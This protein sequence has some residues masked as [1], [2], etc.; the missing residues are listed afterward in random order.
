MLDLLSWLIPNIGYDLI[1]Q[2]V[3]ALVLYTGVVALLG[4]ITKTI[5]GIWRAFWAFIIIFVCVFI[6]SA[7]IRMPNPSPNI[8]ASQ[9]NTLIGTVYDK[10]N[11]PK[12]GVLLFVELINKGDMPSIA[13]HFSLTATVDDTFNFLGI[14]EKL[15]KT[16]DFTIPD[17]R[18]ITLYDTDALYNKSNTP[19]VL[20][21]EATGLLLYYFPEEDHNKFMN[22][23][24][25]FTLSYQDVMG[26]PY[27]L[28]IPWDPGKGVPQ[29][30]PGITMDIK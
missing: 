29:Y 1:R 9:D 26:K 18:T 11:K 19:I 14:P 3:V 16:I 23:K 25:V 2:A 17:G 10:D 20:G 22:H 15:P 6:V 30:I 12:T 8:I 24:T 21:G 28:A 5:T 13:R 7:A 4:P 27:S